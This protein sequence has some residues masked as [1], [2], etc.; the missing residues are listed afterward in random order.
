MESYSFGRDRQR[1]GLYSEKG[2][3]KKTL[4]SYRSLLFVVQSLEKKE[5]SDHLEIMGLYYVGNT[6]LVGRSGLF[7]TIIS[8]SLSAI[9]W[10]RLETTS[11]EKYPPSFY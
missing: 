4:T 8:T 6:V 7:S 5:E 9:Q 10:S 11:G 2:R 3:R 1:L